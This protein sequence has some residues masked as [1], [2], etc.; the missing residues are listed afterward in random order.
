MKH[1]LRR[2]L[3][4]LSSTTPLQSLLALAIVPL[5]W[6][7]PGAT[8][9]PSGKLAQMTTLKYATTGLSWGTAPYFVA[10]A[11]KFFEA[12]NLKV[13]FVVGGQSAQV[14][15]QLLAKAV[16]IGQCALNDVIQIVE[17][18]GAPLVMVSNEVTT[19]LNYGMMAKPSIKNWLDLKG[20]NIIVGGPKDNTVYYTRVMARPNGLK[21]SDYTFAFAGASGARFA[22][23]KSGAVDAALVTDPF[24]AQAQLEGFTRIDDLRPKYVRAE[25]YAGG[26]IITTRD[27]AKAHADEIVAYMRA[28]TKS[29]AW[30]YDP[31]NQDEM[32]DIMKP[33]LNVTR[34]AF[35]QSYQRNVVRDPM[36]ALDDRVIDGAVQGVVDSLVELGNLPVPAPKAAKYY[37]NSYVDMAAKTMR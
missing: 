21:D 28:Y 1:C 26:G 14:C 8:Q 15:Q 10:V 7:T 24:D 12:E 11:K 9:T 31:A 36:W 29:V 17:K 19:A 5:L 33:R 16:E 32:F 23:L 18:S 20:K 6:S 4:R 27:W 25:N 35:N 22:A 2:L 13:E 30:I 34:E 3:E 37:D